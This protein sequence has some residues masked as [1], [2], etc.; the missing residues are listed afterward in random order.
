MYV[1][2]T[3]K[4]DEIIWAGNKTVVVIGGGDTGNDCVGKQ[5]DKEQKKYINLKFSPN[6]VNGTSRLILTGPTGQKVLRSSSVS[7]R[8]AVIEI[9]RWDK[10]VLG[11]RIET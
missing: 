6:P 8:K 10:E 3:K 7:S 9:G 5:S 1:A 4:Q 2:G 11:E